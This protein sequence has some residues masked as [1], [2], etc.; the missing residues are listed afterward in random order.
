MTKWESIVN[1]MVVGS[2]SIWRNDFFSRF[3]KVR[4]GVT[5]LNTQFYM[6]RYT[7]QNANLIKRKSYHNIP[8]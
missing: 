6:T 8:L 2:N 1:A 3:G 5:P 7:G 4:R